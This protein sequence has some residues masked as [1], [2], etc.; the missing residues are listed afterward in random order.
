MIETIDIEY[1][2]NIIYLILFK[3]LNLNLILIIDNELY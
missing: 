2:Q 1:H 3:Y